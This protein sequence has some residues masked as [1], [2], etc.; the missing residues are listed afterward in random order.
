MGVVERNDRPH[1]LDLVGEG[2]GVT[3]LKMV[4]VGEG[5]LND[6]HL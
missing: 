6:G 5:L 1:A 3:L 4:E 2:E